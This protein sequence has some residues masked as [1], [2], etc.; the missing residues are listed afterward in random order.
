MKKIIAGIIA[1]VAAYFVFK[2]LFWLFWLAFSFAITLMQIV[3]ILLLA[4]PL[5][6]IISRK[7]L[8]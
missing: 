8:R 7:L 5:Y 4:V 1:I 3:F 6:V 2:L